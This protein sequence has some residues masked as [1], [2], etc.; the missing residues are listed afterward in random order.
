MMT[1]S[2]GD[3]SVEYLGNNVDQV[4]IV[5]YFF[6]FLW[7]EEELNF[8][9]GSF[10]CFIPTTN[11][12]QKGFSTSCGSD[13]CKNIWKP[14]HEEQRYCFTCRN[15]Y[16]VPCLSSAVSIAQEAVLNENVID[17]CPLILAETA[18]QPA[19]RGG[20]LHFVAGNIR[21]VSKARD[22]FD[23]RNERAK[24]IQGNDWDEER[25]TNELECFFGLEENDRGNPE[26]EQLV[27]RSQ[28]I[29]NCPKCGGFL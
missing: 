17:D 1:W 6:R 13:G 19:A 12:W 5:D 27:V 23:N 3:I 26:R 16:H 28:S 4:P 7:N 11:I 20:L 25:W 10:E 9:V 14:D 22:L 18:H 2:V 29:Y 8:Q 21:I 24:F 15:W